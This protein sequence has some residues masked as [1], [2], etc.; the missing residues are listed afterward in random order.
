MKVTR[1]SESEIKVVI[2]HKDIPNLIHIQSKVRG[3]LDRKKIA[4]Y[5]NMKFSM[6]ELGGSLKLTIKIVQNTNYI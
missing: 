2:N 1:A 3:F 6:K 4:D 5:T